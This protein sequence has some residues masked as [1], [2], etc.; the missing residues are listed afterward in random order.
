[1]DVRAAV[2][3][4][5]DR[6]EEKATTVAT[7]ARGAMGARCGYRPVEG[8]SRVDG[9][10][11]RQEEKGERGCQGKRADGWVMWTRPG[12]EERRGGQVGRGQGEGDGG[13]SA[14]TELKPRR[15]DGGTR[16]WG[17]K[18]GQSEWRLD[19][20]LLRLSGSGTSLRSRIASSPI[21]FVSAAQRRVGECSPA[22]S[23]K[24]LG[25]QPHQNGSSEPPTGKLLPPERAPP[26]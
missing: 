26:G 13:A 16:A 25:T 19:G 17:D 18:G 15:D 2:K 14:K 9:M 20:N 11:G 1:M 24:L 5:T 22:P 3:D 7:T 12:T 21:H 10:V 8:A 6:E 23:S 4:H